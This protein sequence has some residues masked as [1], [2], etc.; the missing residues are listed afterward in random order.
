MSAPTFT[1]GQGKT[2]REKPC[3][4]PTTLSTSHRGHR[5]FAPELPGDDV[6]RHGEGLLAAILQPSLA[7]RRPHICSR[8]RVQK[9]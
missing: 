5:D 8:K 9:H 4:E 7:D 1:K 3:L 2:S 6:L